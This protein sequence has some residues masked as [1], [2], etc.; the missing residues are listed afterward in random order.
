M[1]TQPSLSHSETILILSTESKQIM[2]YT[3][4][5]DF[6]GVVLLGAQED[7]MHDEHACV[8]NSVVA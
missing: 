6:Y 5:L 4:I 2:Q 8:G 3:N 7:H 1:T